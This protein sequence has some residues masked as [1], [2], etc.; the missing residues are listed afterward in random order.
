MVVKREIPVYNFGAEPDVER[1][2]PVYNFGA[3]PDVEREIPVYNFGAEP[4]VEREIPVYN[5]GAEPDVEREIPVYNFGAEP[6]DRRT[7][8]GSAQRARAAASLSQASAAHAADI[9]AELAATEETERAAQ[10]SVDASRQRFEAETSAGVGDDSSDG[11]DLGLNDES[12][13]ASNSVAAKAAA[14]Q[15]NINEKEIR[16]NADRANRAAKKKT[17]KKLEV[18]AADDSLDDSTKRD[19]SEFVLDNEEAAALAREYEATELINHMRK[20][21]R[22]QQSHGSKVQRLLYKE[23]RDRKKAEKRK[24]AE[25]AAKRAGKE[26]APRPDPAPDPGPS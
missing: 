17:N 16:D 9:A 25:K 23:G 24:E 22:V 20:W 5:F 11:E 7:V 8:S 2:I 26:K 14:Y 19:Y 3:E 4:D 1:E 13:R 21:V 6:P 18:I 15:A 10:E 12:R